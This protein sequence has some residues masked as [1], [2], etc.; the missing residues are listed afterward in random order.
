[1]SVEA[2]RRSLVLL[3][4]ENAFLPLDKNKIQTVAV[5]GPNA[6]SRDELVVRREGAQTPVEY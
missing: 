3:K 4:N 5:I 6:N 1:M 2:A